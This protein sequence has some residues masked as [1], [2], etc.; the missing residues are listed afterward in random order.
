[1]DHDKKLSKE[2]TKTVIGGLVST[3]ASM[4]R[5]FCRTMKT[6]IVGKDRPFFRPEVTE[7]CVTIR[8]WFYGPEGLSALAGK[9][10]LADGVLIDVT[11]TAKRVGFKVPVA[12]TRAVMVAEAVPDQ[13]SCRLTD[14]LMNC[15]LAIS[16]TGGLSSEVLF[17]YIRDDYPGRVELV[18]LKAK[19]GPDHDGQPCITIMLPEE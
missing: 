9:E 19:S 4:T 7:F 12:L 14:I 10:A 8:R 15:E 6:V 16:E 3:A 11:E 5:L 2:N 1:M 13:N 17:D 18:T